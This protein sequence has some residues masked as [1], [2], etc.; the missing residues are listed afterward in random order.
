MRT[1]SACGSPEPADAR[2]CRG[3]GSPLDVICEGCGTR[4]PGDPR[5]C[6]ECGRTIGRASG[7]GDERKL[8]TILFADV[9]G[10]TGLGEQLD[11]ERLR[12]VLGAYFETMRGVIER[13]GGTLEKFIGDAIVAIFGVPVAHE[14]DALRALRSAAQMRRALDA[15]N[16]RLSEHHGVT[17]QI[18]VGVHTGEV[19]AVT[20]PRHGEGM[21]TGD[22]V[23]VAARLEQSAA[24]G[25]V[26]VSDRTARAAR[27]TGLR[28]VGPLSLR[29]RSQP[30]RAFELVSRGGHDPDRGAGGAAVPLDASRPRLVGRAA[31]LRR[32]E[33]LLDAVIGSRRPH[34]VTVY[35]DAGVG[36]SRLA[37]E[38]ALAA[39][40][41]PDGVRTVRGACP[42][43]GE[44]LTYWPLA[45]ILKREA[46]VL[47]S[48]PPEQAIAR[49]HL[50]AAAH[51]RELSADEARRISVAL[52]F[53]IGLHDEELR[54][55]ELPPR[56][57]RHETHQAWRAYFSSLASR[58]PTL[59]MIEDIHWADPALLDL[60]EELADRV[61]GP[62]LFLC[63]ARPEL[64]EQHSGWGRGWRN[65][66]ELALEPLAATDAYRLVESLVGPDG[67]APLVQQL[68]VERAEGNPFFMEEI[69]SQL[70]DQAR[71]RDGHGDASPDKSTA[72]GPVVIP[73]TV[74]AVLTAR[75]DLLSTPDKQAL[76][77]ASVVGRTFWAGPLTRLVPAQSRGLDAILVRL[78]QRQLV[79]TMPSSSISGEREYTF[80]HA[81]TRDVAYDSLPRRGRAEAHAEIAR[82]IEDRFGQRRGEF[83]DLL[84]HHLA[85]AHQGLLDGGSADAARLTEARS[86]AF[87]ALLLAASEARAKLLLDKAEQ[88]GGRA[89][90][91]AETQ[92][93]RSLALE[94]LGEAYLLD[95]R[96]DQAWQ[97]LS[98]AIEAR[99]VGPP[100]D[101]L[102]LARLCA[103]ALEVP[104]RWG[105]LR[106]GPTDSEAR[107]YLELGLANVGPDDSEVLVRLLSA[108]CAWPG[109]FPSNTAGEHEV[110]EARRF[111]RDAVGMALRLGRPDLASSALDALTTELYSRGNYREM[112]G[113]I[114][115]RLDL[116]PQLAD[117]REVE[118]AYAMAA[119]DAFH[120][121]DYR[122]TLDYATASIERS[123]PL[124]PIFVLHSFE[125]R[126]LALVRLGRWTE[127]LVDLARLETALG[128]PSDRSPHHRARI[129]AAA[130]YVHQLRAENGPA[131]ARLAAVDASP[132][133]VGVEPRRET[134][135]MARVLA[136]RG[137]FEEAHAW[138]RLPGNPYHHENLGLMLEAACEVA[139]D[140]ADWAAAAD[141]EHRARG[142]AQREDL[143][144]LLG[145]LD[146]VS[147]LRRLAEGDLPGALELLL[148]A[149]AIMAAID[150]R[151]ETARLDLELARGFAALGR[152]EAALQRLGEALPVLHEL[153]VAR[154]AGEA[155]ELLERLG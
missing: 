112:R 1:C 62:L 19:L 75:I 90:A 37:A 47:D 110:T 137:R 54:F 155:R 80:K 88:L 129:A 40:A 103:R 146:R 68:I 84:A 85:E 108:R 124:S 48:D 82:W 86:A 99:L 151:W 22:A 6:P 36:K 100:E 120:M 25:Q 72:R 107:R 134:P 83:A 132:A 74:Q 18:R 61:E 52:C 149:R 38:S 30:I 33:E 39:A 46:G 105:G 66:S 153:R 144:A 32:L 118:D 26:L 139:A 140:E 96:G 55:A 42:P 16:E 63:L 58:A 10:S 11:P 5:F 145:A 113:V 148:S 97:H 135:W 109:A 147:G 27:G 152:R 43:Y 125:W 50:T 130:A 115:Q 64:R 111:G 7:Q 24:P 128:D 150:A 34:L 29:G 14:D 71:G 93:E 123:L 98:A 13:N 95:V 121:G 23:N 104:T 49:I 94:A 2:F 45:E 91:V 60:L 70:A 35:G 102:G 127:F 133:P 8:V 57:V 15:L 9:A 106:H 122:R 126:L 79:R 12:A 44:A 76:Q 92:L 87:D 78:E 114:E 101:T 117:I 17:L 59:A 65:S 119:W 142:Y 154:E 21:V 53:S 28:E 136:R 67:I 3:C 138:L 116:V 31:E 73:D 56:Q 51:L 81:L 41:R 4:V 131:D 143:R 20:A 77:A 141:L 69:V 89:L